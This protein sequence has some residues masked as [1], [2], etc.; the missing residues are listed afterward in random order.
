MTARGRVS[1]GGVRERQ[2][3]VI[4]VRLKKKHHPKKKP[5]EPSI[6]VD[7]H[8]PKL[9]T[10][11]KN[12][13]HSRRPWN[14]RTALRGKAPGIMEEIERAFVVVIFPLFPSLSTLVSLH[15]SKESS[16]LFPIPS[17]MTTAR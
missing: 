3:T 2:Q 1:V 17:P 12:H 16:S 11:P 8:F 10:L 7:P 15:H 13:H 6:I 14:F 4:T 5:D 9:E